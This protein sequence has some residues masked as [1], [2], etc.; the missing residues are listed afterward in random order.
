MSRKPAPAPTRAALTPPPA[1]GP[2]DHRILATIACATSKSPANADDVAALVGGPEADFWQ[3]FEQ[4]KRDHRVN[5]AIIRRAT[6][7]AE[8]LATWPTGLPV[9]HETWLDQNRHG[10]FVALPAGAI[11]QHLPTRPH[12]DADP[13][14]D[15]RAV[16]AG[17]TTTLATER[18][19][20][21]AALVAGRPLVRGLTFKQV[22]DALGVSASAIHYLYDSMIDGDRVAR[23]SISGEDKAHRLYDPKAERAESERL[24]AGLPGRIAAHRAKRGAAL[25]PNQQEAA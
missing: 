17:R 3:A 7:P 5:V 23:G 6:D 10:A 13:R 9:K 1:T 19:N 2:L 20:R 4:L 15:L 8:W 11:R 21:I 25:N 16:T 18:R 12:L 22:A 14:P 24:A